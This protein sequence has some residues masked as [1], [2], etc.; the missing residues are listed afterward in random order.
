MPV[1][2]GPAP[3]KENAM[4]KHRKLLL[5]IRI[6]GLRVKLILMF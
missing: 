5:T 3:W 4:R 6:L 1:A 2:R